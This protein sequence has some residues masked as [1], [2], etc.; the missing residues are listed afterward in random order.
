MPGVD[1]EVSV[2]WLYLDPHYKTIKQKKRT[3][4]EEKGET[5]REEVDKLLGGGAI[6]DLLSP[7]WLENV[8]LVPQPNGTWRMGTDFTNINKAYPKDCFLLP[9]IDRLVDS[10]GGYKVVD[11]LDT[12]RGYY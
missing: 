5:I 12:F 3:F 2:N 4:S 10:S 11:F 9:N 8:V 1:Q 7:T 6:R